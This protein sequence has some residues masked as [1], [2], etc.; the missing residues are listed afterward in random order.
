[1]RQSVIS[2]SDYV[3]VVRRVINEAYSGRDTGV[4]VG[5]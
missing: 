4:G 1:M 3:D 5:W 2:Y